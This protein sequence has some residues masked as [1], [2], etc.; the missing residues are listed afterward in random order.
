M[1]IP[2]DYLA[3]LQHLLQITI[4]VTIG[5]TLQDDE[6]SRRRTGDDVSFQ[7]PTEIQRYKLTVPRLDQVTLQHLALFALELEPSGPQ[8][9]RRYQFAV[10][11][12]A[13]QLVSL[14]VIVDLPLV[15]GVGPEV[16]QTTPANQHQQ[17][18][19]SN[20]TQTDGTTCHPDPRSARF[21]PF[22]HCRLIP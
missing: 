6:L 15:D 18:N 17:A 3:R 9:S 4:E 7:Y 21:K 5:G 10:M 11:Q 14:A 19:H 8:T 2:I 13:N 16:D 22:V 1:K 12:L 20:Q